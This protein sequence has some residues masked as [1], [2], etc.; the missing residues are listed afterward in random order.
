MSY[1]YLGAYKYSNECD[2]EHT[3][4]DYTVNRN[5]EEADYSLYRNLENYFIDKVIKIKD[6]NKFEEKNVILFN[7]SF[8]RYE[9]IR[10]EF[11]LTTYKYGQE[12]AAKRILKKYG[13]K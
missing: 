4:C 5:S 7:N 9:L 13:G 3:P 6:R 2:I 10:K 11:A 8:N 12:K 1:V